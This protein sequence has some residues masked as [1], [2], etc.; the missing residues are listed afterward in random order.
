VEEAV[1][2]LNRQL[3]GDDD[4]HIAILTAP[5]RM[6]AFAVFRYATERVWQ[7]APDNVQEL[8]ERG[9]LP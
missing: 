7:S 3:D 6:A 8:R 1:A 2:R 9:F 5:A 4:D